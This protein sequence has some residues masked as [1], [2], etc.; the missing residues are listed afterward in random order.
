MRL[1]VSEPAAELI[2][3][4]GGR[5][6]VWPKK[7]RCCG[8]LTTL[9]SST[10]PTPGTEFRSAGTL[11]DVE[12]FVPARL[13]PLPDELHVELHRFP[14]RVEAYWNGCAWVN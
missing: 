3:S 2:G 7:A 13:A 9:A 5:L 10:E 6:Y 14:R 12:L 11:G 1:V 8:G 4:R